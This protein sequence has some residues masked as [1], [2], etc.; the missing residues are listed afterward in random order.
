MG[1]NEKCIHLLLCS[2]KLLA[3]CSFTVHSDDTRKE[4]CEE[5]TRLFCSSATRSKFI[6]NE[7][8]IISM[9]R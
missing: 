3:K 2:I 8:V 5:Y 4:V 7:E 9:Y 1:G 6:W